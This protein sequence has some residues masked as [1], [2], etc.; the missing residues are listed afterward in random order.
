[1]IKL[2]KYLGISTDF[3]FKDAGKQI[4]GG[5]IP[6]ESELYDHFESFLSTGEEG[7][8]KDYHSS[9]ILFCFN[10]ETNETRVLRD[11]IGATPCYY[12]LQGEQVLLS[13]SSNDLVDFAELPLTSDSQWKVDYIA[14][15]FRNNEYT[16]Y[17]EIRRLPP[18]F[19]LLKKEN[20]EIE[21][22]EK[23]HL[24][25]E[26]EIF[27]KEEEQYLSLLRELLEEGVRLNTGDESEVGLELSGGLD[28]ATILGIL[29]KQGQPKKSNIF[30]Y[31]HCQ[32]SGT[33]IFK[34]KKDEKENIIETLEVLDFEKKNLRLI[35]R[36]NKG[37]RELVEHAVFSGN[38]ISSSHFALYSRDIYEAAKKDQVG[39]VLSG[40]G[41][42]QV[43]SHKQILSNGQNTGLLKRTFLGFLGK[44]EKLPIFSKLISK[45]N[46]RILISNSQ[47][48]MGVLEKSQNVFPELFPK[49]WRPEEFLTFPLKITK[50]QNFKQRLLLHLHAPGFIYRLESTYHAAKIF[51]VKY[52][53][54]MLYPKLVQAF[55]NMPVSIIRPAER[56]A[57]FRKIIES[58]LP[59]T[60][61]NR[62]KGFVSMYGWDVDA[63]YHDFINQINYDLRN[64]SEEQRFL[65]EVEQFH[66]QEF[67]QSA[68]KGVS[69]SPQQ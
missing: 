48:R 68:F 24:N 45:R 8:L 56:R 7:L 6:L 14:K 9:F 20:E 5:T 53:Y 3:F 37:L 11:L 54:P 38:S 44:L 65:L 47:K 25:F 66:D 23:L 10:N 15:T 35:N 41:G 31:S 39:L 27:F 12:L 49:N 43:L 26:D 46:E 69:L 42:D 32:S 36:T 50:T 63:Y 16:F 4:I 33:S 29:K 34:R 30:F 55:L 58:W 1:M 19:L 2:N 61:Y 21:I 17:K 62:K 51:G 18:G 64:C 60:I 40:W 57:F 13:D 28:C 22:K 67:Y 59:P 52:G